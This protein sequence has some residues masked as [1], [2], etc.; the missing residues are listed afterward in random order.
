M[1]YQIKQLPEHI[2]EKFS[3][4]IKAELIRQKTEEELKS[5]SSIQN[6]FSAFNEKSVESFI[7]NYARKKSIYIT[8]GPVIFNLK[9]NEELKFKVQAENA[10]W[11]IQ[12][13]KLF[14]LQCQWRA[15]QI[16]LNGIEHT[17]Q[18][19]LL[20][21]N[22]QHCP[23]ITPISRAELDL[24]IKYLKSGNVGDLF[25]IDN[26]QDYDGF[27]ADHLHQIS[28][29][30]EEP[31]MM[32]T[33]IPSWYSFYDYHMGTD[34]L[35]DLEDL[36]GEKEQKYRSIAR[37]RHAE[38]IKKTNLISKADERPF[39]NN[40]DNDA[41]EDFIL[42]F[43]NKSL[44]KYYK[45]VEGFNNKLESNM[46]VE[47]AIETLRLACESISLKASEDWKEAIIESA[48]NYELKQIVNVLPIVFQ[49]YH[50]RR[51]NGINYTQMDSDK[52]KSENAFQVCEQAK[53]Q[54][55]TGR[56]LSGEMEDF[57]F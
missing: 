11:T 45:A 49:E 20:S 38:E 48:R 34:I 27:K 24:Y 32:A 22:I 9:E 41:I 8:Q 56:M 4:E 19:L 7:R 37:K 28:S 39:I 42:K 47:E 54:I 46:V 35:L 53:K 57:D 44:L 10:L 52:R 12:Q 21:A 43:E 1:K 40:F 5:N 17:S 15:E 25:W 51:E 29:V 13:K 14:S 2:Q 50:F 16:K 6:Y 55:L 23:F 31:N 30:D 18:F 36:R 26:W 3:E 33:H